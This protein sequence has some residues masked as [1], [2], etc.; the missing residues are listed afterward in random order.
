M[1]PCVSMTMACLSPYYASHADARKHPTAN[2]SWFPDEPPDGHPQALV[3]D[4][5]QRES[6]PLSLTKHVQVAEPII[7]VA[8][9]VARVAE[10]IIGVVERIAGVTEP[11]AGG[12]GSIIEGMENTAELKATVKLAFCC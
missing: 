8:E 4:L 3:P 1:L 7:G 6:T 9:P 12:A 10:P 2:R 5:R 11:V